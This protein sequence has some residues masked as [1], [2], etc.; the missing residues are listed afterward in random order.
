MPLGGPAK[1][2]T[3]A[4]GTADVARLNRLLEA[5]AF[6]KSLNLEAKCAQ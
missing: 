2:L 4:T 6:L 1:A 5:R 3:A